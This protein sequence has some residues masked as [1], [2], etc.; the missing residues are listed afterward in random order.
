MIRK[1]AFL[2]D[3]HLEKKF[4]QRAC[5]NMV[6]RLLQCNGENV[7]LEAIAKRVLTQCRLLSGKCQ[8]MVVVVDR[9]GRKQS[10]V[11]MSA[12]LLSLVKKDGVTDE[13]IVAVADRNIENWIL[14][15]TETVAKM[16]HNIETLWVETPDGFNGKARLKQALRTYHETTTGVDLLLKCRPSVMRS[17]PSFNRFVQKIADFDCWWLEK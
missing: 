17:S 12:E 2:V 3:G 14:A 16:H 5:P 7:A 6:V 9:E 8:P 11:D 1:P 10:A 4:V 15:D 13:L